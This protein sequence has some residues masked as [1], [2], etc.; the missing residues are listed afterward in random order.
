MRLQKILQLTKFF[1]NREKQRENTFTK[2][3]TNQNYKNAIKSLL[4]KLNIFKQQ[5]RRFISLL[6]FI[7]KS[8]IVIV[9]KISSLVTRKKN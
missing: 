6:Q 8:F 4:L 9:E 2:F 3:S 7:R 1:A 5:V